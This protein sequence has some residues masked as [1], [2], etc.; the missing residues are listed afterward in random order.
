MRKGFSGL[1]VSMILVGMTL[2][3]STV[4]PQEI[5]D[6]K[7]DCSHSARIFLRDINSGL[8]WLELDSNENISSHVRY[9][10]MPYSLSLQTEEDIVYV[11][12][13]DEIVY[14][15]LASAE[16][17]SWLGCKKDV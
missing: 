7:K 1:I 17:K 11:R 10:H 2:A 15:Y 3:I 8:L 4:L 16:F 13:D 14:G 6:A 5:N 12:D 9:E